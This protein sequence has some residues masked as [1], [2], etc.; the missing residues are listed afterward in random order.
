MH[1]LL[2]EICRRSDEDKS[3]CTTSQFKR[4]LVYVNSPLDC[5][6]HTP[7]LPT[8]VAFALVSIC[9][10][11]CMLFDFLFSLDIRKKSYE[12]VLWI[13]FRHYSIIKQKKGRKP[14]DFNCKQKKLVKKIYY[15]LKTNV[16]KSRIRIRIFK[17]VVQIRGSADPHPNV[18]DLQH[19]HR[20][21]GLKLSILL[22]L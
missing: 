2:R 8:T 20:L 14:L 7:T 3:S 10:K 21:I 12:P 22:M 4:W 17:S 6:E 16:V 19:W 5:Y 15:F 9:V 11:R 13:R 18:T 1:C